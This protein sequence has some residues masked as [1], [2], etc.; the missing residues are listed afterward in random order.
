[1]EKEKVI[2]RNKFGKYTITELEKN[3]K[4]YFKAVIKNWRNWKFTS[5]TLGSSQLLEKVHEE[6]QKIAKL[7]EEDVNNIDNL[8]CEYNLN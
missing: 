2:A 8:P 3:G 7:I 4:R 1:M 5:D 6:C